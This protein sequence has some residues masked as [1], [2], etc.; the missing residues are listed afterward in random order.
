MRVNPKYKKLYD[1]VCKAIEDI[2]NSEARKRIETKLNS[3]KRYR[4]KLFK[5][6]N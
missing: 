3:S 1:K 2:K 4:I 6:L 5:N